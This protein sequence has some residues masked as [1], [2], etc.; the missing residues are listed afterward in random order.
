M[1]KTNQQALESR[2][3]GELGSFLAAAGFTPRPELNQYRRSAEEGFQC[4]IHSWSHYDDISMLE[5][6]VG[7]RLDA[8]E[9]LAFPMTN[10]LP[11]FVPDSMTLVTPLAKLRGR[12]HHR[13][14]IESEKDV[15]E[16]VDEIKKWLKEDGLPFLEKY[17]NLE[18]MDALFNDQPAK[19]LP[20]IHNAANRCLRGITLAKLTG[21]DNFER[22]VRIYRQQLELQHATDVTREKYERLV[23][24]LRAYSEN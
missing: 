22:L 19:L 8:V 18:A 7:I 4:V 15:E 5:I 16:A 21:R 23:E 14:K 1:P 20:Y 13:Y 17:S 9:G 2:L 24:F 3:D 12:R 11:G 10:G 6:H